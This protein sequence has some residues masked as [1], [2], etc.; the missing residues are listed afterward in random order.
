MDTA[1]GSRTMPKA[2]TETTVL[3]VDDSKFLTLANSKTSAPATR[4]V[5]K[6]SLENDNAEVLLKAVDRAQRRALRPHL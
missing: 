1:A 2:A 4:S 5:E 3:M 6:F